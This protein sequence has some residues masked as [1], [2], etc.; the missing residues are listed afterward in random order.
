MSQ[1]VEYE[2]RDPVSC[3]PCTANNE[4]NAQMK[5][6]KMYCTHHIISSDLR[7]SEF[8]TWSKRKLQSCMVH[9]G[10]SDPTSKLQTQ[11]DPST[12][13]HRQRTHLPPLSARRRGPQPAPPPGTRRRTPPRPPAAK[14]GTPRPAPRRASS[15]AGTA[16]HVRRRPGSTARRPQPR[17]AR[18][19]ARA[20]GGL[21]MRKT[22]AGAAP[23]RRSG[24][25][26]PRP[27]SR[28]AARGRQGGG[29]GAG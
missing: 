2:L 3:D 21:K 5:T 7:L 9:T 29:T 27:W 23:A 10:S 12:S 14:A 6:G 1:C 24:G 18:A 16:S 26:G 13:L 28:G 15:A 19:R 25:S 4:T 20:T 11:P 22:A 17:R 8:Y